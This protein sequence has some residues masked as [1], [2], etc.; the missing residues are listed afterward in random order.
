MTVFRQ[1]LAGKAMGALMSQRGTL[2]SMIMNAAAPMLF[3]ALFLA[4][5]AMA[6]PPRRDT[7][8]EPLSDE[9]AWSRMPRAEKGGGQAA[10]VLGTDA[11]RRTAAEYRRV[12]PAR[13]RPAD[14]EPGRPR[15]LRAAMRWVAAHA[16]RCAYAEAYA[17]AD[18]RRAGLDD[19][20]LDALGREGYPRLVGRRT[21]RARTSPGR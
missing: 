16:N 9:E 11:R 4:S 6:A 14:Q 5:A 3:G 2:M 18:A 8:A 1:S 17:A 21:G 15:A 19:A 7:R 12:P 13:P 10:P 20:R